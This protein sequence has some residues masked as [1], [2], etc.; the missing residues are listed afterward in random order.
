MIV[1]SFTRIDEWLTGAHAQVSVAL[2]AGV[3]LKALHQRP[4]FYSACV[5][6]SQSSA[7]LMVRLPASRLPSIRTDHSRS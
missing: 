3:T 1:F 4:N 6:L 7:N 5:Y 2:A